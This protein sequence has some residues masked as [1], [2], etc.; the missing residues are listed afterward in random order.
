M[1][2]M[3]LLSHRPKHVLALTTRLH[4][5]HLMDNY[6][7]LEEWKKDTQS[8]E[9]RFPVHQIEGSM[10]ICQFPTETFA[11]GCAVGRRQTCS[12]YIITAAITL[13]STL[14]LM[15]PIE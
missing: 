9:S 13:R 11:A 1:L 5:Q 3:G 12:G 6:L 2:H 8:D 7:T 14:V 10:Q 4:Q 15:I